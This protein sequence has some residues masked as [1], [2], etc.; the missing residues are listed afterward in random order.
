MTAAATSGAPA[1]AD[2]PPVRIDPRTR[3]EILGAILLGLFLSALDQ[4][5]VGTALPRIVDD[6]RGNDLYT[7]VFTVY[8]LTSTV[9][10]P[11]YGKLSDLF[12]R[13]PIIMTGIVLFLLGSALSGLSR[14]MW[15]LILFR[16]IQ[17]LGAG[18]LFPVALAVIG[19]L[20]TPAERGKYQGL[21]GAVFGVSALIGPA[22][23]G[24]ITDSI[25]WPWVFFVNLPVGAVA[26]IIIWRTLPSVRRPDAA[27]S[28]DYL[29]AAVFS[30]AIIPILVGLTNKQTADWTDPAVGG[31]I[32]TGLV[33][34]AL[35]VWVES[36]AAEPLVPLSLFANRTF[37][38]SVTA[39]FLSAF[40]FFGAVVF[41]PRWFQV[42]RGASATESGYETLPLLAGLIGSSILSGQIVSR[43]GRYKTVMLVSMSLVAIGLFAMSHLET[44]TPLPIL[45][46]WMLITGLGIGPSFAI[47]TLIVQNAVPFRALGAATSGLVL[48]RQVGGTVGL[49][50]VGTLFGTALRE[51]IPGQ[52]AA[53][54]VPQQFIDRF[55]ATGFRTDEVVTVG[56]LGQTILAG[57]PEQFRGLVEP[58]IPDIV[59]AIH[60]AFSVATAHSF[61]VG[62]VAAVA[63]A[64]LCLW[65]PEVPLRT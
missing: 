38:I 32:L 44:D 54:G 12:G 60:D 57:V 64:G 8:L 27:R 31:L 46:S 29:G 33:I 6:L 47:L 26:L 53:H 40:G 14:E 52:L 21:F 22:L 25:G 11:I 37:S 50:I 41:L 9:T 23:G 36:R 2:V 48:F 3:L 51:E 5:V 4:T 10:G 35:F 56:D 13:R 62:I 24:I 55:G 18:A 17:G 59:A 7:W 42:V 49:A 19:D 63:A 15:Q 20:F 43:T 58:L 28:I 16:G 65:L 1:S 39:S 45:W 34:A 61:L 30:A